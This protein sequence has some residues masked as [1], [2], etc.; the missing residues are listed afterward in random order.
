M[1]LKYVGIIVMKYIDL[2][3]CVFQQKICLIYNVKNER[4]NFKFL[5]NERLF[6]LYQFLVLDDCDNYYRKCVGL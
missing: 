6:F 4:E 3:E 1:L 5:R 2:L